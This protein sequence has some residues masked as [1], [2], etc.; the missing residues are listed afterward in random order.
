MSTSDLLALKIKELREVELNKNE[1]LTLI[2][3]LSSVFTDPE[4]VSDIEFGNR[5][6]LI[7]SNPNHFIYLLY[8]KDKLIGTTTVLIEP[9]IMHD[10][11]S[12][13]HIEDVVLDSQFQGRGYGQTLIQHAINHVVSSSLGCYKVILNCSDAMRKYYEKIGFEYK[14]N[15]MAIYF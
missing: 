7:R 8:Y 5:L 6:H 4:S 3:Q 15:Q 2:N 11:G 10:L 14:N 1:Y 12:I 13:A 9:K